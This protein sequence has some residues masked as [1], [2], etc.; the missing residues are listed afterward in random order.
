MAGET[1]D[2]YPM[3]KSLDM[4]TEAHDGLLG[5]VGQMYGDMFLTQHNRP[6][7]TSYLDNFATNLHSGRIKEMLDAKEQG[8]IKKI[9]GS[10]CLFV[11]EEI[12][13]A[14]GGVEVG[15]CAG[16][17]WAPE[18]VEK[19]LPRNTCPLIKGFT[20]FKL[21][22]VCPYIESADLVVGENT[23][24]GKKKGY[25]FFATQKPMYIMDVP[26]VRTD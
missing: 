21:G 1:V 13:A 15:L 7:S 16:A 5:A 10:F 12:V 22:R 9:I 4:D 17:D 8:R 24:D 23:C 19:H 11:P 6:K 20:G 3:W 2:Y 18:E 25:E 26:H 14:A